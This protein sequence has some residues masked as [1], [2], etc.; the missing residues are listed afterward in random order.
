MRCMIDHI[1][2]TRLE[3]YSIKDPDLSDQILHYAEEAAIFAIGFAPYRTG[4]YMQDIFA[5]LGPGVWI[6]AYYGSRDFKAHW[7]EEGAVRRSRAVHPLIRAGRAAG[8]KVKPGY[9]RWGA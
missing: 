8:L 1:G 7:V 6:H 5:E 4:H 2:I 9:T 3:R